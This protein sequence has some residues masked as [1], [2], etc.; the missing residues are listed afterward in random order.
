MVFKKR[1]LAAAR[2][3]SHGHPQRKRELGRARPLVFPVVLGVLALATALVLVGCGAGTITTTS[4]TIQA[5][6]R[7]A[8]Q[9]TTTSAAQSTATT[10]AQTTTNSTSVPAASTSGTAASTSASLPLI[11]ETLELALQGKIAGVPFASGTSDIESITQ[12]WGK[13]TSQANAGAGLYYTYATHYAAFG[14]NKGLQI[15]DVRSSSPELQAITL[16]QVISVLGSPGILRYLPGQE[17]LL[18]PVGPDY[19]LL[20]IFPAPSSAR[21]DPHLDH[22]SVFYPAD[23]VD[24]M[25]Q[26]V[27]NPSILIKQAPGSS[28]LRFTFTIKD[29]PAGRLAPG[30][31]LAEV[32]WIPSG[33]AA[34]VTTLPQA[35]S[36]GASGGSG[37]Y[38]ALSSDGLTWSFIYTSAMEGQTGAVRLV[39]QNTEGAVIIGESSSVTLK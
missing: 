9:A 16:S 36:R 31:T 39:Y 2:A 34:V 24:L 29:P 37:S 1:V 26:D 17:I 30:Y 10:V 23:T 3:G 15:F 28:G 32:D 22:I 20:W 5:T 27:P 14:L 21:P 19:Q 18:Y 38:F 13:P 7:T 33:G 25:A 4:T 12:A 11:K 35:I 6:T 8:A